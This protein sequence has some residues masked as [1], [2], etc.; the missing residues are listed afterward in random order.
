MKYNA[1]PID[2]ES[3]LTIEDFAKGRTV[4]SRV[5]TEVIPHIRLEVFGLAK[6][7]DI[8]CIATLYDEVGHTLA[9]SEVRKGYLGEWK[10]PYE[11]NVFSVKISIDK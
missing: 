7:G 1:I 4:G 5:F 6:D 3:E 10:V 2:L 8:L 9:S 11:N